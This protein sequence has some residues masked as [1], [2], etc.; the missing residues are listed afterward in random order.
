MKHYILTVFCII[1]ICS[2][3]SSQDRYIDI[4]SPSINLEKAFKTFE[5]QHQISFSYD[6]DAV[7][8]FHLKIEDENLSFIEFQKIIASEFGMTLQ[9][10]TKDNFLLII[11]K[12]EIDFCLT[13]LDDTGMP[14]PEVN[15]IVNKNLIGLTDSEGVFQKT[16]LRNTLITLSHF[17]MEDYQFVVQPMVN[18]CSTITLKHKFTALD[19][20]VITDYLTHGMV[21]NKNGSI[22]MSPKGLGIL[23]GL[24]EP[25][26]FQSLQ[27]IPGVGSP[28]EDPTNLNIRGGTPDQNL[29][30]FDGIKMYLND[31]FFDQMSSYNPYIV[32]TADVYRSGTGVKYGERIS[33]VID[34]KSADD[35]FDDVKAGGGINLTSADAFVKIPLSK[36]FGVMVAGRRSSTDL[37]KTFTYNTLSE[38]VFQNS[39]LA[40]GNVEEAKPEDS[41]FINYYFSD[42][43]FKAIWKPKPYQNIQF[44]IIKIANQLQTLNVIEGNSTRLVTADLLNQ[45]NLGIGFNWTNAKPNKTKKMFEWYFSNYSSSYG[46]DTSESN[47]SAIFNT[48]TSNEFIDLGYDLSFDIPLKGSSSLLIGQQS[49]AKSI[50]S[51]SD[52]EIQFDSSEAPI[53]GN[54]F[55]YNDLIDIIFYSEYKY[56]TENL[57]FSAGIRAGLYNKFQDILI[58]PRV[59]AHKKINDRFRLTASAEIKNQSYS[60]F[61][62]PQLEL[63]VYSPLPASN[64]L[65]GSQYLNNS[66]I[67][68]L[69]SKQLTLGGLYNYKGWRV[70]LESYYKFI[71][72]TLPTNNNF[73]PSYYEVQQI[74][75][76][77]TGKTHIFGLDFLVKKRYEN[78]RVWLS[79]AFNHNKDTFNDFQK[80]SYPGFYNQPHNL[81]ISQTYFWNNFEF[82]LGWTVSSGLPFTE[83]GDGTKIT[84]DDVV[85]QNKINSARLPNYNR[86]DISALYNFKFNKKWHGRIGFS[87]R[88]LFN[89]QMP[90]KVDYSLLNN[91][92]DTVLLKAKKRQS[93]GFV[94]DFVVRIEF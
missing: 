10:V 49:T 58:E 77:E 72:N 33:G 13:I 71:S 54:S 4:S 40:V 89:R 35:L 66:V 21:K 48:A 81:N 36:K 93:L 1:G 63:D 39:R 74:S 3:G 28:T 22:T 25:D 86:L 16:L 9:A 5:E 76:I 70:E 64:L 31:H 37:Y 11:D 50:G 18:G 84:L 41:P 83:I 53:F 73:I 52:I 68:I 65:W 38:K 2:L 60:Q 82:G 92:D 45:S 67:S 85:S 62:I 42:V 32:K 20:V 6:A 8:G 23:P 90:I 7:D 69:K 15:I 61:Y 24:V 56:K 80:N 34:I 14:L 94:G 30:L 78:Y 57:F 29:I 55:G 19:A 87:A 46:L 59:Y 91:N 44:S 88:N 27:L 79:Y 51:N 17:S 26:I 12:K 43:N 47:S 75:E